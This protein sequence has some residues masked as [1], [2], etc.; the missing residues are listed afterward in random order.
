MSTIKVDTIQN[1]SGVEV[2]TAKAWIFYN[3]VSVSVVG[4]GNISSFTDVAAGS[5]T[6]NFDNAL[7]SSGYGVAG[8][9]TANN[10]T[11]ANTL[12]ASSGIAAAPT[13]KTTTALSVYTYNVDCAGVGFII[14]L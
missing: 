5:A 7:S 13:N 9:L 14:T 1:T 11:T 12:I 4:D 3:Q 8:V 6:L 2:Y 10:T